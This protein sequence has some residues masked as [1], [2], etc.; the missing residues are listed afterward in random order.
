[1]RIW[2]S[3]GGFVITKKLESVSLISLD[4]EDCLVSVVE[5][6]ARIPFSF[7]K[8]LKNKLLDGFRLTFASSETVF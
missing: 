5:S 3:L 7:P 1:M 2:V 6:L 8:L 4:H